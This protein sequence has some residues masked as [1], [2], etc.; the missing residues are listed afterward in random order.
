VYNEIGNT[1][2]LRKLLMKHRYFRSILCCMFIVAI[3]S[4]CGGLPI[5]IPGLAT[6]TPVL[7]T[8][9]AYRQALPPRLIET[10]PPL[11]TVIGQDSPI[12]FYFNQAMNK[13]SVESALRGLPEGSFT[14]NDEATLVFNPIQPYQPNSELNLTIA[15]S[16]QSATGFGLA[17]PIEEVSFL[18]ADYLRPINILPHADATDVDVESAVVV[19][20]NQPVIALGADNSTLPAAFRLQPAAEGRG[21]WIN[22]STY[23]FYPEPAMAGGTQYTLNLNPELKTETGVGLDTTAISEWKFT[24]ASPR[25]VSLEPASDQKLPL[26]AQIKLTFNQP[27]DIRL[28]R[29]R[30]GVDVCACQ[31]TG[32]Q[33]G[34]YATRGR[35]GEIQG[36]HGARWRLRR[37]AEYIR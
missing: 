8:P 4:S 34:L 37:G 9:T 10:D 26:D 28:E 27:M 25:V 33:R 24:T 7:P 12:T 36:R 6:A 3:L 18:V 11:K 19:S 13:S 15:S 21:E 1:F 30:N 5:P 29:G 20:F 17:D 22:T 32:T 35:I 16:V 23:I 2:S 31:G 14:W